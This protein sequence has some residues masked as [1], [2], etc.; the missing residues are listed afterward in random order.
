M[1]LPFFQQSSPSENNG[2]VPVDGCS[3]SPQPL[4][5]FS[6]ALKLEFLLSLAEGRELR[7][8][9]KAELAYKMSDGSDD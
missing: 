9:K 5:V 4:P 8:F 6:V 3:V 2:T 1:Y 7:I